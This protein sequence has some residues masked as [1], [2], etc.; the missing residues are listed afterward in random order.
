MWGERDLDCKLINKHNYRN[1]KNIQNVG[2]NEM[3]MY[4]VLN[5]TISDL[6]Q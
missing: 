4:F 2:K 3:E 1:R 5:Y 6:H